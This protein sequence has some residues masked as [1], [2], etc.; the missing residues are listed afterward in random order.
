[1]PFSLS[2]NTSMLRRSLKSAVSS[3]T[4]WLRWT[5]RY[6]I[7]GQ[8]MKSLVG[9]ST[10]L[11]KES[12][13]HISEGQRQNI[14]SGSSDIWFPSRDSIHRLGVP[15]NNTSSTLSSMLCAS[16]ILLSFVRHE[17]ASSLTRLIWL[18]LRLSSSRFSRDRNTSIGRNL[19]LFLD[20]SRNINDSSSSKAHG[21]LA[22]RF[23]LSVR[24]V[25]LFVCLKN[26]I[27]IS[28]I[29]LP[30]RCNTLRLGLCMSVSS[31]STDILF[32]PKSNTSKRWHCL[33]LYSSKV[34]I[35][36]LDT[37]KTFSLVDRTSD[38]GSDLRRL[39]AMLRS[40]RRGRQDTHSSSNIPILL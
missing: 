6:L 20:T 18:W 26:S 1:M 24:L 37:F 31:W 4:T 9:S 16:V 5:L 39:F 15:Q 30:S 33:R 13:I 27:G 32:L 14:F 7:S 10:I 40:L 29:M 36:L 17:K 38:L 35:R 21:K 28:S 8:R 12:L 23:A 3:F 2:I 22:I 11:L 34:L 25:S 19:I